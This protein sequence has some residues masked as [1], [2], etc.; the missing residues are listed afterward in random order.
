M[1]QKMGNQVMVVEQS[2]VLVERREP[3]N[4]FAKSTLSV[5]ESIGNSDILFCSPI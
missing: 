3:P 5:L 1:M 4:F 2:P